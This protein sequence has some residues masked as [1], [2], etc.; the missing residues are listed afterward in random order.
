M[1]RREEMLRIVAQDRVTEELLG[2]SRAG[3]MELIGA[4]LLREE[5]AR[6]IETAYEAG[7][8]SHAALTYAFDQIQEERNEKETTDDEASP[9]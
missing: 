7:W 8:R 5:L 1:S 9:A 6:I 3:W 2:S 4:P